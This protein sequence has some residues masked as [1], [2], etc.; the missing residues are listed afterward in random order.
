[1]LKKWLTFLIPFTV[2]F[3]ISSV[4]WGELF[5]SPEDVG[6]VIEAEIEF[7]ETTPL[8]ELHFTKTAFENKLHRIRSKAALTVDVEKGDILFEKNMEEQ[9]P[10]ASLTKLMT[11][12]VFLEQNPNLD[13]SA[14]ITL[15]DA[16]FAGRSRLWVGETATLRD[17][18]HT[19][20]M[21][22]NNRTTKTLARVSGLGSEAFVARMNQKAEE[23]GLE[24]TCFY[25]PTG[26]DESNQSTALDCARLLSF[27]LTDSV[28]ASITSK[29]EYSFTS[30]YKKRARTHRLA[31]TNRLVLSPLDVKCGKTGYNG[32]SG[33][34]LGTLV[35][36]EDGTKIAA[37][38]LGAPSSPAR[39][40]EAR[41]I[42]KWS[43]QK[44]TKG[45]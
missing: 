35:Q 24:N 29:K 32:A 8:K 40:R 20:L 23:I 18:L 17:L 39:F 28:V 4:P 3:L 42:I 38:I 22:S 15:S 31:N 45:T 12:L 5:V 14:K 43:S 25:E 21:S 26:L 13:D 19:S 27:A 30:L 33:W 16:R 6:F 7:E 34:C 44:T 10:I 36:D 2:L 11:A 1:L 37:V 9:L 41:S